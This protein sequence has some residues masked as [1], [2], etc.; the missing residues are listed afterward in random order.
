M[1]EIAEKLGIF[2]AISLVRLSSSP[3][4]I[5][6]P[7]RMKALP[8]SAAE[9]VLKIVIFRL[10]PNPQWQRIITVITN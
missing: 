9:K 4:A 3:P 5:P 8:R 6:Q 10:F 1:F 7:V 2:L